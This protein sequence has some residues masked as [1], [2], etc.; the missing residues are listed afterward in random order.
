MVAFT[1]ETNGIQ[2]KNTTYAE[3]SQMKIE[4]Q[5]GAQVEGAAWAR[6]TALETASGAAWNSERP[7]QTEQA[8]R[9]EGW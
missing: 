8:G 1:G 6:V 3:G 5:D 4:R 2:T 7:K 9:Q